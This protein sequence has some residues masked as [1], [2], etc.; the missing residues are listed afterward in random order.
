MAARALV[1]IALAMTAACASTDA[2]TSLAAPTTTT[3]TLGPAVAT[4]QYRPS[5]L[6]ATWTGFCPV[7]SPSTV[8][9]TAGNAYQIVNR[10]DRSVGV[11]TLPNRTPVETIAADATGLTHTDFGAV[12][13]SSFTY[14][15][16][17]SGCTDAQSGQGLFSVTVNSK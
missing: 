3:V 15:L 1:S 2:G 4:D 13:Q 6:P 9:F 8:T 11:I 12:S 14:S 17:I 16:T 10:T 5:G 7:A